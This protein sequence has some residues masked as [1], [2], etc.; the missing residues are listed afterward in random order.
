MTEGTD[1]EAYKT[2]HAIRQADKFNAWMYDTIRPYIKGRVLEAGSGI[3][4]ISSFLLD[5]GHDVW[6]SDLDTGYCRLLDDKFAGRPNLKGVL[7][8]NLEDEHFEQRF[9]SLFNTFDTIVATNVVEHIK[10]DARAIR[11]CRMLLREGG[12][13]V[14]LVPVGNWLF[15]SLDREFG[16]YRRYS[17]ARLNRL[18]GKELTVI[19]TRYFN[20]G[21][22]A[23]WF[24]TGSLLQKRTL[25]ELEMRVFNRLVPVFKII[26]KLLMNRVGL[27]VIGVAK[28][29]IQ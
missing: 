21:G 24:F 8:L 26:D 17:K 10:D 3:G 13:L 20:F 19:H 14:V 4:N 11:N 6:L 2:L 12:L 23:G 25:P 7:Q 1:K 27:S 15:N 28:K 16:H 22:I 18:L 29:E 5:S 9:S